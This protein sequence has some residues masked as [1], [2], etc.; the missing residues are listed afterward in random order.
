M[1]RLKLI[2]LARMDQRH[3]GARRQF[4]QVVAARSS[5]IIRRP[6][7]A[8]VPTPVGVSTP[9]RPAPAARIRSASVPCGTR[10]TSIVALQHPLLRHRIGADMGDDGARDTARID[11]LADAEAWSRGVVRNH[12]QAARTARNQGIDDPLRRADAQ[13]AADNITGAPS[14]T[15]PAASS[16]GRD[17]RPHANSIPVCRPHRGSDLAGLG[18]HHCLCRANPILYNNRVACDRSMPLSKGGSNFR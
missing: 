1:S 7:A 8:S 12:C 16:A 13:E 5:S 17:R 4:E 9:P 2:G 6:W 3:V 11:Q 18:P 10:S 14:G 15:S